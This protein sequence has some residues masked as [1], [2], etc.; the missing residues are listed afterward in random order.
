MAFAMQHH[1]REPRSALPGAASGRSFSGSR[2]VPSQFQDG[3][4]GAPSH[5]QDRPV[6]SLGGSMPGSRFP[7]SKLGSSSAARAVGQAL[8]GPRSQTVGNPIRRSSGPQLTGNDILTGDDLRRQPRAGP[9]FASSNLGRNC[10]M[11]PGPP[12]PSAG[13]TG[14]ASGSQAT[15][16]GHHRQRPSSATGGSATGTRSAEAAATIGGIPLEKKVLRRLSQQEVDSEGG[17][18]TSSRAPQRKLSCRSKS[19]LGRL[20]EFEDQFVEIDAT[21]QS[22]H[23]AF[24]SGEMPP[25]RAR[26]DLAQLEALLDKLQFNGVDCI[27]TFELES[28]KDQARA[29]RKE[30]TKKADGLHERM[31]VLF[32]EI[33][34]AATAFASTN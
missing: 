32:K 24:H 16:S 2:T 26:D 30:L 6:P 11:G 9:D 28:G 18:P 34:E 27:D 13:G 4:R 23:K 33:K 12:V 8:S 10:R 21:I 29:L 3:R 14:S 20:G 25:G 1:F 15:D 5:F 22:I 17:S 19:M 31:E 7:A